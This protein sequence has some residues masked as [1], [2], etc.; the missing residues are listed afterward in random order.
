MRPKRHILLTREAVSGIAKK[1]LRDVMM[2]NE[3]T[4][5][6]ILYEK[7]TDNRVRCWRKVLA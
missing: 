7:L 1:D 5:E 4:K 2:G 3:Q 6:N